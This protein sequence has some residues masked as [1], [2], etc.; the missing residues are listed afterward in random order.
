[1]Y[2]MIYYYIHENARIIIVVIIFVII[3]RII[4]VIIT[5]TLIINGSLIILLMLSD[6]T[7]CMY[8]IRGF[9]NVRFLTI[10]LDLRINIFSL[11][12]LL[13]YYFNELGQ[14]NYF[15]KDF[16]VYAF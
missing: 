15:H 8:D 6:C 4:K 11:K 9:G 12:R 7:L 10:Q 14:S 1:M 13:F 3:N 5:I 16:Q 2:N